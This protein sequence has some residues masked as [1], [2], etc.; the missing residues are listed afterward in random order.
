MNILIVSQYFYPEDF[1]VNDIAFE[2]KKRGHSV[3]VLTGK[4]NY[5][6]G[7][8]FE[9]YS[10][11]GKKEE[12]ING[13]KIIR[14]SLFPRG[15]G[16]GI[17]L[18]LNYLSFVIFGSIAAIFRVK[19]KFDV[20]FVH[21]VSPITV[22]LPAI[23]LKKKFN[24]PMYLW[25]LDLW[26]ESVT[27]A[28]GVKNKYI[29][30]F[31]KALVRY[32]Y[33][34]SDKILVSSKGFIS[35]IQNLV[36]RDKEI[37]YFPNWAEEIFSCPPN[38]AIELP[39]YPK[40]FNILFAGNIGESQ[41][42]EVII[43]AAKLTKGKINW[44]FVGD[45]R[46]RN[47]LE[48]AIVECG[49]EN[50]HVFGRYPLETMPAFFQK[51][52]AMLITLKNEE[53][54]DLIVPAKMQA[55]LASGKAILGAIGKEA[56]DMVHEANVGYSCKPDDY[57]QLASNALKLS[58]DDTSIALFERNSKD[59]YEKNFERTILMDKIEQILKD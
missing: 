32:I 48:Q 45:G 9:G 36:G 28:G 39:N 12:N 47:M 52:N 38:N 59:F 37:V 16:S 11:F 27:A 30:V 5:P 1:K 54:F 42:V 10:F 13:V 20:V 46:K 4:P 41:N 55:Y 18:L 34:Y 57:R 17:R 2:M 43:E 22:A 29:L 24:C 3:T 44:I 26:P 31:L 14:C 56:S 15:N 7:S 49:I 51:A 53:I 50:I 23:L 33:N 25:V 8:F 40:G 6:Q 58:E 19:G 21:E 35:S